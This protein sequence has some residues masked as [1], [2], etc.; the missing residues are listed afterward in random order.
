MRILPCFALALT[1]LAATA[2][3]APDDADESSTSEYGR[4]GVL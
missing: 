3:V 1:A 2:C 4:W